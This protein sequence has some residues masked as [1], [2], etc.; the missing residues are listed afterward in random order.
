MLTAMLAVRNID[1]A[2]F[3]VW[4]V[5]VEDEYHEAG[6]SKSAFSEPS[7]EGSGNGHG[8]MAPEPAAEADGEASSG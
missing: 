1:G 5:N 8:D 3:D 4:E 6:A 2:N 7:P